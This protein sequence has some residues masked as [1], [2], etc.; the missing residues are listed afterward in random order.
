MPRSPFL[1][2]AVPLLSLSLTAGA[3]LAC[4]VPANAPALRAELL[5]RTNTERA[6]AGLP[7]LTR[8]PELESAAQ[9]LACDNARRNQLTHTSADGRSLGDR[10]ASVGYRL[11]A[12]N[13]NVARGQ[14]SPSAAMAAWMNS[15]PHRANTLSGSVRDFGAGV[16]ASRSGELFWVTVGGRRR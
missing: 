4:T 2:A 13:E 6:G 5:A 9:S 15:P 10:L 16:A 14:R 12:A 7:A 1:W 11:R 3:A 8:S